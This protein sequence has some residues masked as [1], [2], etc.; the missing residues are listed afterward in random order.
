MDSVPI[1][2]STVLLVILVPTVAY[3]F[4]ST[5]TKSDFTDHLHSDEQNMRE[6]RAS[7]A[8]LGT[9][10]DENFRATMTLYRNG[11]QK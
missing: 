8:A 2:V 5:P 3:I 7:L 4:V 6:I 10:M 11:G 1:I 9:K